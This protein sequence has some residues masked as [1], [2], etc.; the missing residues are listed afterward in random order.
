MIS[1]I[2]IMSSLFIHNGDSLKTDLDNY[3]KKNLSQYE[4]FDYKVLQVPV[5]YKK[6]KLV[7]N[8]DFNL[9]GNLVYIPVEIVTKEGRMIKS[10]VTLQVKLYKYILVTVR[11][12]EKNQN[13]TTSDIELKKTDITQI[14]GST[15]SSIKGISNY[16]SKILL[17]LGVPVIEENIEPKPIILTG[18]KI[19]AKLTAGDVVISFDAF[20]R[21][22]G[23]PGSTITIISKDNKQ[24][25]AK[26]ID[27]LN[28][29][30]IE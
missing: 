27:S 28:V 19:E 10:I 12:I 2:L 22:D 4:S 16:R 13:F 6:F 30:I 3:L 24:Y 23:I 29:N 11:Q 7:E 15:L 20:S 17:K 21:Q 25:K 18:D 26:V 1:L 9:C 14:K 8:L 5:D